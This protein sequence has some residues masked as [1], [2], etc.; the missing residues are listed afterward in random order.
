MFSGGFGADPVND[1]RTSDVPVAL[2]PEAGS[3]ALDAEVTSCGLAVLVP[4][5]AVDALKFRF[6]IVC[7][8]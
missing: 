2:S 6:E 1:S 5:L 4:L 7:V 8:E 3:A